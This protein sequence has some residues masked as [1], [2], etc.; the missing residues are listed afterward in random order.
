[1]EVIL[2]DTGLF[3]LPTNMVDAGSTDNCQIV[4]I[5][6]SPAQFSVANLGPNLVTLSVR[7]ASGNLSTCSTVVKVTQTSSAAAPVFWGTPCKSPQ[8][9]HGK[10]CF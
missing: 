8:I 2:D 4:E 7:D 5:T 3:N 9:R 10:P 1:M 6:V